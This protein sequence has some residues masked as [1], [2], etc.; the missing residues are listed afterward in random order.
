MQD[1]YVGDVGDFVKYGLLRA[2]RGAK[3][4]GV[5]WYLHPDAGPSGDGRYIT[6]LEHPCEW[7]KLDPELFDALKEVTEPGANRR[8]VAN[9][10]RSGILGEAAFAADPP[11]SCGSQAPGPQ[12]LAAH[13]VRPDQASTGRLRSRVRR[14]RQRPRAGRPLP[15]DEKGEREADSYRRSEGTGGR[16]NRRDLSPQQQAPGWPDQGDPVVEG[17]TPWRHNGLLLAPGEQPD[18]LYPQPGRTNPAATS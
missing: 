10:Q 5:A 18:V 4:L 2:I 12:A 9:I 8:S 16:T 7:R 11:G 14:P 17:P 1:R 3:R 15:A 13:L 6:Y